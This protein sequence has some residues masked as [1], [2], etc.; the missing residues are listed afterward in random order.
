[1]RPI[2]MGSVIEFDPPGAPVAAG[3]GV[4]LGVLRRRLARGVG[5]GL[6]GRF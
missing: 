2:I 6:V 5:A 1:M 4:E 3:I